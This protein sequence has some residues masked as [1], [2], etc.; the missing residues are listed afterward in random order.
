MRWAAGVLLLAVGLAV[1]AGGP[2]SEAH[3]GHEIISEEEA[4]A[5]GRELIEL[6][7]RRG[8]VPE[9]WRAALPERAALEMV[10][11]V[12]E[13]HLVFRNDAEADT[14]R[15]RLYVFLNYDG[16]VLAANFTGKTD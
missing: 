5:E 12:E 2:L 8:R 3:E 11:G 15:R 16:Q 10:E 1:G 7:V 6:L 14:L 4:Y 9:T 13:W